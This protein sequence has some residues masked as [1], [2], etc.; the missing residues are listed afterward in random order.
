MKSPPRI[1]RKAYEKIP[2]PEAVHELVQAEYAK[3][4][5]VPEESVCFQWDKE[6]QTVITTSGISNGLDP[7]AKPD[8][9]VHALS[10]S[11]YG[12]LFDLLTPIMTDWAQ[13]PLTVTCGYGIRS[14]GLGSVLQMHRDG[15]YSHV[16]SC[17][18]HVEDKS[19]TSWPLNFIDHDNQHH[20]ITFRPGEMLL[21]ESLCIHGRMTP[22]SG[23]YYRNLYLHWRPQ[24]WNGAAYHDMQCK[25]SLAE[26]SELKNNR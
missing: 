17:I 15:L 13:V 16:I 5:F 21:Y 18:I 1:A 10:D 12:V 22:F 25:F 14:Y 26:I 23:D 3:A 11:V 9:Q 7:V 20:E 19:D 6:F 2:V 8:V 24:D 4:C